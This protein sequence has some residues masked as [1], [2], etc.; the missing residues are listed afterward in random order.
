MSKSGANSKKWLRL[1]HLNEKAALAAAQMAGSS[2]HLN[3][4][5]RRNC[6]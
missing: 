2:S 6:G 1:N 3:D 4:M 5:L